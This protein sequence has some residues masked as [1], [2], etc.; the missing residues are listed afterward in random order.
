[1]NVFE[2][3]F[4]GL[5]GPTHNYAGLSPGNIAS[6]RSRRDIA[7]PR[8]A[9]LQGLDKMKALADLG[10][11]QA[12]LPPH[13]RPDI[14]SLRR[15]GFGG[16]SDADVLNQ[17]MRDAPE[18]LASFYSASSMWVA[19]AATV[20]SHIDS[21]DGKTHFTP[22][23]LSSMFHRSMESEQSASILKRIFSG[24]DY[25]HH[26]ALPPGQF[27]ADEGAANHTRLCT[28]HDRPG[29]N[30]FVY[31]RSFGGH[32]SIKPRR[33]PARQTLEASQAIARSH[34]IRAPKL[35]FAQQQPEAIDAGVFHND[36]IAV[37][38]RDVLFYHQRAFQNTARLREHLDHAL[39]RPVHYHE[40]A[41]ND[42]S[43]DDAV[44]TYL[45]N[46]QLLSVPGSDDM[47]LVAPVECEENE[48]VANYLAHVVKADKRISRII[49]FDL[50][51]SMKN[52]GGPACLRLRVPM[53]KAQI[54]ACGARVFFDNALYSDL[55]ECIT[56]R[57]RDRLAP[58]DLRDPSLLN[59]VRIA[60]DEL[61]QILNLGAIY[62]FQ[63]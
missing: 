9:A 16:H 21:L 33:F 3:N 59:E 41:E 2:V 45:F 8:A 51:Q 5:V 10:V 7:S 17:L 38:H 47:L 53:S 52:G 56:R 11:P 23:N 50:R 49:Y 43:L 61:S 57:Y 29:V 1:M 42:I 58:D 14:K 46:T 32:C 40:V 63:R 39:G 48:K 36:V 22:A 20:T 35:V 13:A 19:N 12:V 28:D 26:S 54:E 6:T 25:V 60:L 4:D 44:K 31:G 55:R 24:S 18:W 34:Q 27:F 37:G 30:F 62:D 15:L